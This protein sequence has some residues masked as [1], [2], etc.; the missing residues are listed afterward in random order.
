MFDPIVRFT[1]VAFDAPIANGFS[2]SLNGLLLTLV[3]NDQLRNAWSNPYKCLG[4]NLIQ[5]N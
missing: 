3:A 2:R 5:Q 4:E 1:G